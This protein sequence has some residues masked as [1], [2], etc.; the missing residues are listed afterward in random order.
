VAL[1]TLNDAKPRSR[2]RLPVALMSNPKFQAQKNPRIVGGEEAEVGSIPYQISFQGTFGGHFCGGIVYDENHIITAAHCCDG[3]TPQRV[4]IVAGEHNLNTDEGVEQ[5]IAVSR[6]IQH[7]SYESA[8]ITD[9]ICILVLKQSLKMVASGEPGAV[10]PVPMPGSGDSFP[11]GN[12][13]VVSGW[14]TTSAGGSSAKRLRKVTV[15]V[16]SDEDCYSAYSSSYVKR[17][18]ICASAKGKDSC[19]GDSGGPLT[20]E[21]QN[22]V[23]QLCGIV[24]WGYGCADARYP[25][26]YTRVTTYLDWIKTN[27]RHL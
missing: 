8:T 18:H 5:E 7:E 10:Q 21:N 23:S 2:V 22:G 1:A 4:Q 12:E 15:N 13:A 20:C 25:G 24:S 14:G 9:D 3:F 11:A 16:D 26:V 6:I 27:T 17:A 19:Q